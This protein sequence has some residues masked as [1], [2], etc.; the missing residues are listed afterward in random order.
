MFI[1]SSEINFK[2]IVL[3]F[4]I[5]K[6][7]VFTPLDHSDAIRQ[8]L[9]ESGCGKLG[10]YDSCSFSSKGNGRFRALEGAAP[11]IESDRVEEE[12]I[13]VVCEKDNLE[14]VIKGLVKVHPY[15]EPAIDIV[16][17]LDYH[18]FL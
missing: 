4:K 6:I 18:S 11:F 15:E 8:Y 14:K 17:I 16:P 12:R 13:E 10:N 7:V 9:A 5:F 1:L 2:P 3:D